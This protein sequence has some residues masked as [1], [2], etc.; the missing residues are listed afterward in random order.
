MGIY[1]PHPL[2]PTVLRKFHSLPTLTHFNL[3]QPMLVEN[4]F[5]NSFPKNFS[6]NKFFWNFF[7]KNKISK[8]FYFSE[9]NPKTFFAKFILQI[10]ISHFFSKYTFRKKFQ[11]KFGKKNSQ[12]EYFP[13]KISKT[14]IFFK[15][16][17]TNLNPLQPI[18][19]KQNPLHLFYY[20]LFTTET[21]RPVT[22]RYS[23]KLYVIYLSMCI[24]H[25]SK[26]KYVY[27]YV[28]YRSKYS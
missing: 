10:F 8:F 11:K 23:H 7:S 15:K 16:S 25:I 27:A 17:S 20:P 26:F 13:K 2:Q 28:A 22:C 6:K 3:L 24:C 9:K 19:P 5:T 1:H 12:K 18:L 4:F 14:K 21:N